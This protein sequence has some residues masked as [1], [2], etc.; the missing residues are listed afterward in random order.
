MYDKDNSGEIDL[1]EM[2][3]IFCLMYS[4]QV[5]YWSTL[6]FFILININSIDILAVLK[7]Y[8]EEEAI[9]RAGKVFESLDKNNDGGLAE[10]EFVKVGAEN[11]E[12]YSCWQ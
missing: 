7:G 5:S 11:C 6:H 3:E 1:D 9:E 10:D 4:I 2:V 8:T 12:G